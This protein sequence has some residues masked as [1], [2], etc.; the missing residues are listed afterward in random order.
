MD[1]WWGGVGRRWWSGWRGGWR[2]RRM[3][4]S[5]WRRGDAGGSG[6]NSHACH[7]SVGRPALLPSV[8]DLALRVVVGRYE[9]ASAEGCGSSHRAI[10]G[11][12]LAA[13]EGGEVSGSAAARG[14]FGGL[15]GHRG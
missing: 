6:R 15:G 11:D 7:W 1:E 3:L 14:E 2:W 10:K 8:P 13:G 12:D 9:A 4:P 5:R